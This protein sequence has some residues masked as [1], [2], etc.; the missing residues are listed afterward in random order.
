M[1][2]NF[3]LSL[4]VSFVPLLSIWPSC[5]KMSDLIKVKNC[6]IEICYKQRNLL[7]SQ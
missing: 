1:N 7:I 2:I 6:L 5:F 3:K 4:L